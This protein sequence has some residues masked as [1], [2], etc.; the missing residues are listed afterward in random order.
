MHR[1]CPDHQSTEVLW[2]A[3]GWLPTDVYSARFPADCE[4]CDGIGAE[5]YDLAL[6]D[7][8]EMR[9]SRA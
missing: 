1:I 8:A 3:F 6:E 4:V 5:V 9:A 2:R 7:L